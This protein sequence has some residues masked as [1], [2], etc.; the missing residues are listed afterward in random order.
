VRDRE[1]DAAVTSARFAIAGYRYL[2]LHDEEY[3]FVAASALLARQPIV[4]LA[5]LSNHTLLDLGRDLPLFRYLLD[6]LG[7]LGFELARHHYLGTIAAVRMRLLEGAG[8]AVLPR[9]FV[10]EDLARARLSEV[11]PQLRLGHDAFRLVWNGDHA[12][13]DVL[14]QLAADLRAL[15]LR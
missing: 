4:R 1:I 7:R 14:S 15:S 9:Y 12:A 10:T 11:L 8:V 6:A 5:D 13:P 2:T 3:V